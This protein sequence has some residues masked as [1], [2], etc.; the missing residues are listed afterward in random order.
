[1]S[2]RNSWTLIRNEPAG[3]ASDSAWPWFWKGRKDNMNL[4]L[5]KV[6]ARLLDSKARAT[7]QKAARS[8]VAPQPA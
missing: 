8:P 5:G 6:T 1:M 4:R 7:P 3:T 2:V